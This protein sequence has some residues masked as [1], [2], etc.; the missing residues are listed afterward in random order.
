[1]TKVLT[2]SAFLQICFY[3]CDV[4]IN[5]RTLKTLK[6]VQLILMLRS[7]SRSSLSLLVF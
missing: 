3:Y 6:I 5:F 7:F 4:V 2:L 1:M